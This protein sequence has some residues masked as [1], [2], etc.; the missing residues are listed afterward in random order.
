M[1]GCEVG[2]LLL[3]HMD[4]LKMESAFS[5][6]SGMPGRSQTHLRSGRCLT[7][8]CYLMRTIL[9]HE[10]HHGRTFHHVDDTALWYISDDPF[11]T[12][13]YLIHLGNPPFAAKLTD[14]PRSAKHSFSH[15]TLSDRRI[16]YDFV[17]L[18]RRYAANFDA[19]MHYCEEAL[20][21][22]DEQIAARGAA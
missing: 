18:R 14:D 13:R 8:S 17:W 1:G 15:H 12:G 20:R 16:P 10:Y 22:Y 2:C 11:D 3:P 21:A 19:L 7:D 6:R 4:W 5:G 9:T